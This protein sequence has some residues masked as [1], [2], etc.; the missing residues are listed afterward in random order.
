MSPLLHRQEEERW[1]GRGQAVIVVETP[2]HGGLM[3]EKRVHCPDMIV[4]LRNKPESV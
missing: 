2:P 3:W 1:R 4:Y